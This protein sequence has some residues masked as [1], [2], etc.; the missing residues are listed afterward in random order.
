MYKFPFG[1]LLSGIYVCKTHVLQETKLSIPTGIEFNDP[2]FLG[3][4]ML[5]QQDKNLVVAR[6]PPA[7]HICHLQAL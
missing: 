6:S 3:P 4:Y 7:I 5:I 2:K 1:H